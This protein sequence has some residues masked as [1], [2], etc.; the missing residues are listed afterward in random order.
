MFY[1]AILLIQVVDPWG[2]VLVD[3]PDKVD[4]QVVDIDLS[5]LDKRRKEMPIWQHRR[6]DLY[7]TITAQSKGMCLSVGQRVGK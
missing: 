7:G 2:T 5:Y 1:D 6:H 3:I 4:V